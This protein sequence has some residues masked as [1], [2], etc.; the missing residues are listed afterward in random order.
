MNRYE[1]LSKEIDEST[2]R[3]MEVFKLMTKEE[4]QEFVYS[5]L[6]DE[7]RKIMTGGA[8][9]IVSERLKRGE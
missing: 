7:Q 6:T 8:L 4:A 1:E 3:V 2:E 9:K 5:F